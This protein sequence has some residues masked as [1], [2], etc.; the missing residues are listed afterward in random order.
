MTDS[1]PP[2]TLRD[3]RRARAV[4]LDG[5]RS[6]GEAG[7]RDPVAGAADRRA[8][9]LRGRPRERHVPG[10]VDGPDVAVGE[11]PALEL[12][13][14][15]DRHREGPPIEIRKSP[16]VCVRLPTTVTFPTT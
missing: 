15:R 7:I 16:D 8:W 4:E 5:A 12:R 2:A 3:R 11:R 1:V 10:D 14:P 13:V 9:P 6:S